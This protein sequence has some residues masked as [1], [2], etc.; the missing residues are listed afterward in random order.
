MKKLRDRESSETRDKGG[1]NRN[2]NNNS[3][4]GGGTHEPRLHVAEWLSVFTHSSLRWEDI[5][6]VLWRG[7]SE[8]LRC[9][10]QV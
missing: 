3:N 1:S 2:S 4:S 9:V 10:R 6:V 5:L 8:A 7:D